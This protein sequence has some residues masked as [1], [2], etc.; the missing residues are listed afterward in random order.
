MN[1][2]TRN[3]TSKIFMA[4]QSGETEKAEISGDQRQD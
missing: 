3:R 2:S 4:A 1:R